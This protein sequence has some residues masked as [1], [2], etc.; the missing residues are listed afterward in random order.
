MSQFGDFFV[1][2]K[3]FLHLK[4]DVVVGINAVQ[5]LNVDKVTV[6]V[7]GEHILEKYSRKY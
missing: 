6:I 4:Q 1:D 7:L 2:E 3:S 5:L